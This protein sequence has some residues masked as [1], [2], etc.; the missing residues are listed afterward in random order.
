ML[1]VVADETD[2]GVLSLTEGCFASSLGWVL[3]L[4]GLGEGSDGR[5][6]FGLGFG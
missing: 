6:G 4:R 5:C 3:D 1:Q 2:A